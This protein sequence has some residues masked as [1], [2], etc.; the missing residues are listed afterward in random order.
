[1]T[2]KA[3]LRRLPRTD[4][5]VSV[6]SSSENNALIVERLT[7]TAPD[8]HITREIRRSLGTD[9]D[10]SAFYALA[11]QHDSLWQIVEPLVGLPI[12]RAHGVWQA[13]TF[14]IIEQHISWVA[15][16]KSQRAF[17]EWADNRIDY[18]GHAYYDPPEIE[19]VA[20]ATLDDL[21]PVKIT[22]KRKRLLIDIAQRI[23]QGD[24]DLASL[25]DASPDT[26]YT[27]LLSIKGV[28]HWTASVVVSRVQG[29]FPQIPHNDVALQAAVGHY[30]FGRNADGKTTRVSGDDVRQTFATFESHAG[31][32]AYFTLIRWVLDRYPI[33]NQGD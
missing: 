14:V 32:A 19:Q 25:R 33:I 22:F 20:Q 10:L 16:Q 15:A 21:A 3:Y 18:N 31:L 7:G 27:E 6:R 23:V 17:V 9:R 12:M 5:V 11:R 24:L 8:E 28:G 2:D 4:T 30:F 1:M 13:L 26:L 29:V